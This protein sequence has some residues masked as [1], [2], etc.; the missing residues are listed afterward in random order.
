MR[1]A[2]DVDVETLVQQLLSLE[3]RI[4]ELERKVE[5]SAMTFRTKSSLHL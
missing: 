1:M 3:R 5:G 2:S 4:D